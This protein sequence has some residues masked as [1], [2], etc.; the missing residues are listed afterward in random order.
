M[1]AAVGPVQNH[2]IVSVEAAR[3]FASPELGADAALP[4]AL[5]GEYASVLFELAFERCDYPKADVSGSVFAQAHFITEKALPWSAAWN[6]DLALIERLLAS[7]LRGAAAWNVLAPMLLHLGA[8]GVLTE[9]D[10]RLKSPQKMFWGTLRLPEADRVTF[11]CG[12]DRADIRLYSEGQAIATVDAQRDADGLWHSDVTPSAGV[13][14]MCGHPI[15]L[16]TPADGRGYPL[17]SKRPAL[18]DATARVSSV[19]Q[20][21][22][23]LLTQ[24]APSFVPW[25]VNGMRNLVALDGSDGVM[26]SASVEEFP[27]LTFLSFPNPAVQLAESLAHEASHHH[28]HA[29]ERLTPLHDG[30]DKK[31]YFSPIK[32]KGRSIELTL[33]AFHAFANAAIYHRNLARSRP[34][35]HRLNGRTFDQSLERIR[36]LDGYLAETRALT[37]AGATLWKPLSEALFEG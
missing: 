36:V 13:V 19:L 20:E 35:Y 37:E 6:P 5:I 23:D 15:P 2:P 29:L 24:H 32:Q 26:M 4:H 28:F 18:P 34:E 1:T 14:W 11:Q 17:P 7:P 16:W 21:A 12:Q 33:Y 22:G 9:A 30:T 27:G 10:L 25:I 31:E 3:F 8:E